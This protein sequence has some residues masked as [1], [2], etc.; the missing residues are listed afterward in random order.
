MNFSNDDFCVLSFLLR[1]RTVTE[2]N[3]DSSFVIFKSFWNSGF[4]S[5]I[6]G[7]K[8]KASNSKIKVN[9]ENFNDAFNHKLFFLK[10]KRIIGIIINIL[11][12]SIASN[13]LNSNNCSALLKSLINNRKYFTQR[14]IKL[15]SNS[16]RKIIITNQKTENRCH[17]CGLNFNSSTLL[18]FF[19]PISFSA[20][21][22]GS[23]K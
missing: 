15:I 11:I 10:R 9:E 1:W 8:I 14:D 16:K 3:G 5:V 17:I 4:S 18:S 6:I 22:Q 21:R 13:K 2:D 19:Y 23:L 20:D 12:D 7:A